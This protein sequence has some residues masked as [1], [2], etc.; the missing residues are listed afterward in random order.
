MWLPTLF[1]NLPNIYLQI[2]I[3]DQELNKLHK[4]KYALIYREPEVGPKK[5]SSIH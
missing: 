4:Y 2:I 5:F 3:T 1:T